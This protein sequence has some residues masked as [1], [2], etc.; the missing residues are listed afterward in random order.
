MSLNIDIASKNIDLF[1]VIL[2]LCVSELLETKKKSKSKLTH[3]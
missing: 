3:L 1:L 2:F